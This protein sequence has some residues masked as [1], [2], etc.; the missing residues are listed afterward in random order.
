MLTHP[1][2]TY[3]QYLSRQWTVPEAFLKETGR[4]HPDLSLRPSSPAIGA[5]IAIPNIMGRADGKA[6][7]LGAL[8]FGQP[9]PHYGPRP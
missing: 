8:Q 5:G 9:V 2:G 7:D 6:P 1:P 4:P 3:E